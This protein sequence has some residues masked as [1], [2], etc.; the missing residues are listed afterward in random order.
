MEHA[1][2]NGMIPKMVAQ[3]QPIGIKKENAAKTITDS[4]F[5]SKTA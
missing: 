4:S 2:E 5:W 3:D 1:W